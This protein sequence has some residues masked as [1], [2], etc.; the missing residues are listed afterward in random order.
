MALIPVS[1]IY[2]DKEDTI[3]FESSLTFGET[4]SLIGSSVDLTDISKPKIDLGKYRM[5][6]LVLTI[7]KAPFKIGDMTTIKM[8]DS[9]VVKGMLREITRVHP[10]AAYI[11][12]WMETFQVYEEQSSS[13]T[14][15]TTVVPPNSDGT[16]KQSTSKK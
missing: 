12:D 7:K 14:A 10:L 9:K 5:N 13:S 16:K 8:L 3:E 1:I 11:E 6:L 2:N 4:E 15:S